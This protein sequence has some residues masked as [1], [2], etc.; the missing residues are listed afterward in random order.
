[1]LIPKAVV[2]KTI[3]TF[4]SSSLKDFMTKSFTSSS[5]PA[6]NI[7]QGGFVIRILYLKLYIKKAEQCATMIMT[8]TK[9]ND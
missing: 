4:P 9:C 5:V 6:W 3:L 8:S 2:A 1:M 7:A